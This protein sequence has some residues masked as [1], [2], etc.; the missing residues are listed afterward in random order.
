MDSPLGSVRDHVFFVD[1]K[2]FGLKI[3]PQNLN[4]SVEGTLVMHSDFFF[5]KMTFKNIRITQIVN[6]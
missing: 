6:M 2:R 3:V 4:T 1:M 5:L